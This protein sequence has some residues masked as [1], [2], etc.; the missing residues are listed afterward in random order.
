M[1]TPQPCDYEDTEVSEIRDSDTD[2]GA[3][4]WDSGAWDAYDDDDDL[5]M[6]EDSGAFLSPAPMRTPTPM[7]EDVPTSRRG[8]DYDGERDEL[9]R[10]RL[11]A[12]GHVI[13]LE[14]SG[15]WSTVMGHEVQAL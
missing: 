13:Y 12:E 1:H 14:R 2:P 5:D 7:D 9:Y 11:L 4:Y 3:D 8:R 6:D 15:D 10:D